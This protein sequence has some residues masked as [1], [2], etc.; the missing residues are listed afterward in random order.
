MYYQEILKARRLKEDEIKKKKKECCDVT[1][2]YP[3]GSL[4]A[5]NKQNKQQPQTNRSKQSPAESEG[6]NLTQVT[7]NG[8][9]SAIHS[10][11]A[12]SN[13]WWI[14]AFV[15]ITAGP[16]E[17]T[18]LLNYG[19]PEGCNTISKRHD[20]KPSFRCLCRSFLCLCFRSPP[21][22][23]L[24]KSFLFPLSQ[25]ESEQEDTFVTSS[26]LSETLSS[27]PYRSNQILMNVSYIL[28]CLQLVKKKQKN[29]AYTT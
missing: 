7:Q 6:E 8:W 10:P 16:P 19:A 24:C 14:V 23:S 25:W 15:D 27:S 28:K 20:L 18:Q 9:L 13:K 21:P 26:T 2:V 4:T 5:V 11:D 3:G 29:F 17:S 1:S 12:W 22:L